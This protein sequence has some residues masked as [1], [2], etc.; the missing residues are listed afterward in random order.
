MIG[1]KHIMSVF[2]RDLETV[3]ALVLHRRLRGVGAAV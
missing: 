3:Q 1:E 2:D